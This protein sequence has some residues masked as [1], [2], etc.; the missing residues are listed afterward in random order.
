MNLWGATPLL[1][2]VLLSGSVHSR[3]EPVTLAAAPAIQAGSEKWTATVELNNSSPACPVKSRFALET[4]SPSGLI[5]ATA[6]KEV[7]H[8][9]GHKPAHCNEVDLTFP[10]QAQIPG[11]AVLEFDAKGAAPASVAV[12]FNRPVSLLYYLAAPAAAG[13]LLMLLLLLLAVAF[14]KVYDRNGARIRPFHD[15]AGVRKVNPEFWQ[16]TVMASGAWTVN[17]SWATNIATVTAILTT[18]F[19]TTAAAS[20]IFPGVPL[21]RFAL[22]NVLAGGIIATVP[23]VFAA[24]YARWTSYHPGPTTD[25]IIAPTMLLGPGSQVA[26]RDQ[27]PVTWRRFLRRQLVMLDAGTVIALPREEPAILSDG[28]PVLLNPGAGYRVTL[29]A[30]TIITPPADVPDDAPAAQAIKAHSPL[31]APA[32]VLLNGAVRVLRAPEPCAWARIRSGQS[33]TIDPGPGGAQG[34]PAG[35][36]Q[37]PVGAV[38]QL[39]QPQLTGTPFQGRA[40]ALAGGTW[41]GAAGQPGIPAGAKLSLREK[42]AIQLREQQ[43]NG[44]VIGPQSLLNQDPGAALRTPV[45]IQVPGGATITVPGGA[46]LGAAGDPRRWPVQ[47]KDGAVV[48]VPAGSSIEIAAASMLTLPGSSDVLVAGESA[49]NINCGTGALTIAADGIVPVKTATSQQA[50][51]AVSAAAGH[52]LRWRRHGQG[53]QDGGAKDG[54]P[55]VTLRSPVCLLAPTGAKI[56]VAGSADVLL[57]KDMAMTAPRR[58]GYVLPVDRHLTVPQPANT[59]G[60][61]MRLVIVAA[62]LT[63][64][65][66]GAQLG[67]AGVLAFQFSDAT[68]SGQ[69]LALGLIAGLAVFLLW[70]STTAIRSLADPQP[71]SSMSAVPGTSFTL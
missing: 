57:P 42:T 35:Q 54:Q 2:A 37:L 44:G 8:A 50:R 3:P 7:N 6:S 16:W 25:T 69:W 51:G 1:A 40:A 67:I 29:A 60:A 59:L 28:S 9:R 19:G 11:G 31:R 55:D 5:P 61:T 64:F 13:L 43:A 21:D 63:M 70:Y 30:G 39:D 66:V 24:L 20:T 56:T 65:G 41:V 48:Q 23:L 14:V 10:A 62:L 49:I 47:V 12:S 53:G 34:P 36:V 46:A 32:S 58:R 15:K 27:T 4:T 22:V 17:D 71:G 18:V 68:T 38:V 33:V 52:G 26:L 45:S